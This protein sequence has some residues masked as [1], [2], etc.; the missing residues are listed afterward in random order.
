M[1]DLPCPTC[2]SNLTFLDQ[3]QRYYCHRCF[4]YAPEGYGDHGAQHCPT[5]GGILS[6]VRQ[7]S[8]MYCYHCNAYPPE[9]P[10]TPALTEPQAEPAPRVTS[11]E[12]PAAT[13]TP[14]AAESTA[15]TT[16]TVL[17]AA[18]APAIAAPEPAP[19]TR[20]EPE[21]IQ[22]E[23]PVAAPV[24]AA[25]EAPA[26]APAEA[27]PQKPP[28]PSPEMRALAAQKPAAVRVKIFSL[29]K[30]ELADLATVYGIDN[31][32]G[33]DEVQQ[34]L[35]RYL[36][37]LELGEAAPPASAAAGPEPAP[38]RATQEAQV[39]PA[40]SSSPAPVVV[41][42]EPAPASGPAVEPAP[43]LVAPAPAAAETVH[44]APKAEHPC[45]TCGREL[46]FISQYNRYYCYSCQRYAPVAARSRNACPTCGATMRWIDQHQRWWCDSCQKYASADLPPPSGVSAAASEPAATETHARAII[47]HHHGS[48]ASG[49]G[50]VGFGLA[51]YVV[52]AFFAYLGT[53]LGFA[54]PTGITPETLDLI[55][56]FA[57]ALVAVGA[58][59]G[60]YGLRDRT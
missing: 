40:T 3:Y 49:A 56:F 37:D 6:Y 53:M 44:V 12:K 57:F 2:G 28:Q 19:E 26:P 58:I 42:E 46:T 4:Q 52:Y 34:R 29:K 36:H 60:L 7:Y 59:V 16:G 30:T 22:A 20:P 1:A 32:G 17:V 47:V 10:A 5:C 27:P 38:V 18:P 54:R 24:T 45:P 41:E 31:S 55:Q 15:G 21:E 51:L 8:R 39:V 43:I 48:P 50:L 35:L 13:A 25:V 11:E 33:K 9:V 23:E 14:T